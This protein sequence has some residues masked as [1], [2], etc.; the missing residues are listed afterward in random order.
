M[1]TGDSNLLE[2]IATLAFALLTILLGL[3]VLWRGR[4]LPW[5]LSGAAAFLLGLLAVRILNVLLGNSA[6]STDTP[7]WEN[8][9]PVVAAFLGVLAGRF[10]I[11]VAYELVGAATGGALAIWI[12]RLFLPPDVGLDFWSVAFILL[13]MVLGVL[14]VTRYGDVALIVLSAVVGPALILHG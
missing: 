9:I 3:V 8:L 7:L 5:L 12:A 10:R 6:D 13:G 11:A 4:R 2:A 14:F 1:F